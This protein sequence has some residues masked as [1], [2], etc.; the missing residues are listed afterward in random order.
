[1]ESGICVPSGFD[2]WL[3]PRRKPM[4][5]LRSHVLSWRGSRFIWLLGLVIQTAAL[6]QSWQTGPGY[7]FKLLTIPPEGKTGF[8]IL[9]PQQTGVWFTNLLPESRHLTNQI[10]P[11]GSGAAAGD[12]DR[13]GR[14]DLFFSGFSGGSRLYRNLG[15]WRFEDITERAGVACPSL[16]ATGAAFADLDGDG[17]LDLLVGGGYGWPRIVINQGT[18]EAY[19]HINFQEANMERLPFADESFDTVVST[20]TLEHVKNLPAAM[21]ELRRVTRTRLILVTPKQRPYKYTFDLHL[22]FFPYPHSL[23]QAV[24]HSIGQSSCRVAGGDLFY[25]ES[26]QEN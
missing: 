19:P 7:R 11:N 25:M 8:T 17:D 6:A 18:R 20:H 12:V 5:K 9:S 23:V 2:L 3:N 14:C 26:R 16:D 24:G 22:N 4:P 1:M 13:D 10:L 21:H 15:N